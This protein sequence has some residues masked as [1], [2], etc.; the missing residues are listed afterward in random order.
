MEKGRMAYGLVSQLL[1]NHTS[2]RLLRADNAPLIISF[3]FSAF[4]EEFSNPEDG[5]IVEKELTDRLSDTLYM[6]NEAN[7][8]YP[9]APSEYLTDWSNAGFLRKYPGSTDEY[10]Y[11]LTPAA[12]LVFKW[13]DSLE[14]R[15]FIGTESRLKYLFERIQKLVGKTQLNASERLVRLEAQ[16][17]ALEQ[18]IKNIR[19]GKLE[20]LDERQIKEEYFLIEDT[21]KSLLADFREVEQN[22]RSLDRNFRKQIITT[23]Q[24]KGEVL[25]ELFEQQDFLAQTDQGKSFTAFWEFLLSQSKQAEFEKLLERMLDIPVVRQMRNENFRME[26]LRNNLIEAGD[27]TNKTTNSLWNQLRKYLEHKSFFE[28]KRIHEQIDEGLKLIF[29]HPEF[30]FTKLPALEVEDVIRIDLIGDRPLFS[31]P[32]QVKFKKQQIQEGEAVG[33]NE[34]LYQ[35]FEINIPQLKENIS[36]MLLKKQKEISLSELIRE[37]PIEKGLAEVV[38]YLDIA[39]KNEKRHSISTSEEEE[40]QIRNSQTDQVFKVKIPKIIFKR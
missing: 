38:A 36:K 25:S 33:G 21:A 28:N 20:M 22:F 39:S 1:K 6:L 15:E 8:I 14:K 35:Q 26:L 2:I 12:E 27:R 23:S 19:S 24:T 4:K 31:P 32:E 29:E 18:E 30:D 34:S 9:T 7:T 3:L 10:V 40:I 17:Q 16:K 11:E 13:M 5:G 37:Y